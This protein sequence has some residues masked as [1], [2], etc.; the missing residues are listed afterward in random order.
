MTL[1]GK[2]T[3]NML[4]S[5]V[6]SRSVDKNAIYGLSIS[7]LVFKVFAFKVENLVIRRPPS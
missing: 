2:F 3:Q 7:L 1:K 6:R 5:N 4:I